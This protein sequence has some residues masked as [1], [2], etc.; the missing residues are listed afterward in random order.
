MN[1]ETV[2]IGGSLFMISFPSGQ[3][4]GKIIVFLK[5]EVVVMD[6]EPLPDYFSKRENNI[7][8]AIATIPIAWL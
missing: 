7:L 6:P 8:K 2:P 4:L 3:G 5:R 1:H